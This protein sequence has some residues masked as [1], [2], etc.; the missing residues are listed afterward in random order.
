VFLGQE[1]EAFSFVT[2]AVIGMF[3]SLIPVYPAYYLLHRSRYGRMKQFVLQWYEARAQSIQLSEGQTEQMKQDARAAVEKQVQEARL[4]QEQEYVEAMRSFPVYL[5]PF[6]DLKHAYLRHQPALVD[7]PDL[8]LHLERNA[9][10]PLIRE[11]MREDDKVPLKQAFQNQT[12]RQRFRLAKF[13]GLC[14]VALIVGGCS[15]LI[16]TYGMKLDLNSCGGDRSGS[17]EWLQACAAS[18]LLK[19]LVQEPLSI[20]LQVLFAYLLTRI[21]N[22]RPR[23]LDPAPQSDIVMCV[24]S[25][26]VDDLE[27]DGHWCVPREGRPS[28]SAFDAGEIEMLQ[29]SEVDDVP[30]YASPKQHR[31]LFHEAN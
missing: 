2:I 18:N 24:H 23:Q 3:G 9:V 1:Q 16:L 26:V 10:G 20:A 5:R 27:G 25:D 28:L 30:T 19:A 15:F 4:A 11:T 29:I 31:P 8:N 6:Y 13:W 17:Y 21:L 12:L 14:W 22:P 7:E